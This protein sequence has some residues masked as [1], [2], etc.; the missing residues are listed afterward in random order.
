AGRGLG[1]NAPRRLCAGS[2]PAA[3]ALRHLLGLPCESAPCRVLDGRR[4]EG[5]RRSHARHRRLLSLAGSGHAPAS[6]IRSVTPSGPWTSQRNRNGLPA[7]LALS[8]ASI[9]L[10]TPRAAEGP[11][12]FPLRVATLDGREAPL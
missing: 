9:P 5:L 1:R 3:H 2:E 11:I 6:R 12:V 10:S 8:L 7:L 4:Q